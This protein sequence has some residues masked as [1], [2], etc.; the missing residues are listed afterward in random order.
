MPETCRCFYCIQDTFEGVTICPL[1]RFKHEECRKDLEYY[2]R[3]YT[4]ER[5]ASYRLARENEKLRGALFQ[6]EEKKEHL[7]GTKK[8]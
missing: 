5:S 8:R 2:R 6:L 7:R 4:K 3:L 1:C